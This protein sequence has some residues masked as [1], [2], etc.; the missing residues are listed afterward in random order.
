MLLY[1][2]YDKHLIYGIQTARDAYIISQHQN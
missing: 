2:I 1:G